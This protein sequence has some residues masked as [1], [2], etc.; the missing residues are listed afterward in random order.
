[1]ILIAVRR[2]TSFI[3]SCINLKLALTSLVLALALAPAAARG[4]IATLMM[5]A[6]SGQVLHSHRGEVLIPPASLTKMMTL[7]LAFEALDQGRMK[8]DTPVT[9]S[10]HAAS[11]VPTKMYFKAGEQIP[12]DTLIQSMVVRSANDG[13]AAMAEHLGGSESAFA[14]MMT[15]KARELG[16]SSTVFMTA[17]GLPAPGQ[18][19]NARDMAILARALMYRFPHYYHYFGRRHFAYGKRI[20]S[21]SNRLLHTNSTVDGLK[22]GYTRASGFNVAVTAAHGDKRIILVVLGATKSAER[23]RRA[24]TLLAYAWRDTP[25]GKEVVTVADTAGERAT[26]AALVSRAEAATR[27]RAAAKKKIP[28][29]F[30]VQLGAYAKYAIAK[31]AAQKAYRKVPTAQRKGAKISIIKMRARGKTQFAARL[32]GFDMASGAEQTCRV[33]SKQGQSCRT[34]SYPDEQG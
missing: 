13:A 11:Q 17:S 4:E 26:E 12:V 9:I 19:T 10:W 24:E 34:V 29:A 15:D 31:A 27:N 18:V 6:K 20:Y 30:G 8:L 33:L 7:Y 16:M 14:Q 21:N 3:R 28:L 5:D 2:S 22:T 1:M 25:A 32:V 23:Y